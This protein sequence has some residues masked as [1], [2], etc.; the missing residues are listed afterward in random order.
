MM[1]LT[2]AS[3]SKDENGELNWSGVQNLQYYK[4]NFEEEFIRQTTDFYEAESKKWITSLSCPEYVKVA[5]DSLKKEEEKVINFLDKETRPKLIEQLDDKIVKTHAK[6][7]CDMD[8]TGVVEMLKNKRV[9]ELKQLTIL[10]NRKSETLRFISEKLRPYIVERGKQIEENKEVVEDPVQYISKLVELKKEM[11]ML[12]T[13]AF[14]GIEQFLKVNDLAFQDIM[15][16]FEMA[17]RFM[18]EYNDHLMRIGL[19]GKE[20]EA[21]GMIENVFGLFKLLKAKDVF[22]ERNKVKQAII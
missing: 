8:K 1:G 5:L 11:D 4:D 15:D 20:A 6:R 2:N 22:T 17:P 16:S 13:E 21:E 7:L 19:R 9:E 12:M 14:V 10:L 3:V 18:A